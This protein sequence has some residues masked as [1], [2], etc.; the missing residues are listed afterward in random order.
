V[1]HV[2]DE[3]SR[4]EAAQRAIPD[5]WC[6][7]ERRV[8]KEHDVLFLIVH[9]HLYQDGVKTCWRV[10]VQ[11]AVGK[12]IVDKVMD[13]MTDMLIKRPDLVERSLIAA[14]HLNAIR[15]VQLDHVR[16]QPE[17]LAALERMIARYRATH[18]LPH[19]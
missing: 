4:S 14:L 16:A 1:Q 13:L 12:T 19:S 11:L 6:I 9:E 18:P 3:L 17:V 7:Y 8:T 2:L 10:T 15:L 5:G